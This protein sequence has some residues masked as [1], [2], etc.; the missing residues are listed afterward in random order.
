VL[1]GEISLAGKP[2]PPELRHIKR[3]EVEVGGRKKLG[4]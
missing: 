3:E 1:S 4:V 2:G